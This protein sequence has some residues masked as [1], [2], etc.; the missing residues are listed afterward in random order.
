MSARTKRCLASLSK[1]PTY[2][3]TGNTT[4][5]NTNKQKAKGKAREDVPAGVFGDGTAY[6]LFDGGKMRLSL[7]RISGSIEACTSTFLEEFR[8]LCGAPGAGRRVYLST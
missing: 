6:F 3:T 4:T 8:D 2:N 1:A 5:N 7:E